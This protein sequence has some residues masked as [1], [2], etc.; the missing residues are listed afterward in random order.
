[1]SELVPSDDERFEAALFK[2]ALDEAMPGIILEWE[3][4]YRKRADPGVRAF[5]AQLTPA[6]DQLKIRVFSYEETISVAWLLGGGLGRQLAAALVAEGFVITG[7]ES[8]P[9]SAQAQDYRLIGKASLSDGSR[10]QIAQ[11]L[12]APA[13]LAHISHYSVVCFRGARLIDLES[14]PFPYDLIA[15]QG[16][17]PSWLHDLSKIAN[18]AGVHL[19][20]PMFTSDRRTS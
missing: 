12:E 4:T 3:R 8:H 10:W 13:A 1:M 18:D 16:S 20:S 9:V 5:R 6:R 19:Y 17:M 2:I 11:R 7:R 15:R 14:N